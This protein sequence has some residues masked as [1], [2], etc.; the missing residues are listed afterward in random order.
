MLAK[1]DV[2]SAYRIVPIHPDDGH[3]LGM[4]M[5]YVDSSLPFGL[6][7][8]LKIFTAIADAIE[9]IVCKKGEICSPLP[10][11]L[12]NGRHT[13]QG[14][15]RM[16]NLQALLQ[17]CSELGVP[18]AVEKTEGPTTCIVLLGIEIDS[19]AMEL[20][21]PAQK[22][23]RLHTE[24]RQWSQRKFCTKR[25]LQSLAGSLQHACKVVLPDDPDHYHIRLCKS[26]QT[27]S[28]GIHFC[29]YGMGCH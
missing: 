9:W 13:P 23:E 17:V 22:L 1:T 26:T 21:L 28:G 27:S 19:V 15:K 11:R 8:A 10:R 12:H 6:R 18:I 25:E 7:S 20:R 14:D 16:H 29:Q 3:L 5:D 2:K 4:R 24:I